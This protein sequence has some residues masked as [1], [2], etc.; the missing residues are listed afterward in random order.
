MRRNE[1]G[2]K[3]REGCEGRGR[4][5]KKFM[6]SVIVAFETFMHVYFLTV[7]PRLSM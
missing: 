1:K 4:E 7:S 2:G 5:Y 6:R 3:E